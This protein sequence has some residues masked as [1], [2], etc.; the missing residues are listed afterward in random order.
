MAAWTN[1][2]R[3]ICI[4][5]LAEEIVG[6]REFPR[7]EKVDDGGFRV[8]CDSRIVEFGLLRG[9]AVLSEALAGVKAIEIGS[10]ELGAPSGVSNRGRG[11]VV[12]ESIGSRESRSGSKGLSMEILVGLLIP[13]GERR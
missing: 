2:S 8:R 7:K 9:T 4:P 6:F 12:S 10:G 3:A 1:T 11:V 13:S 5:S